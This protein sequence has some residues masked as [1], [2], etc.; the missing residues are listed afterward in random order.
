[1]AR[2]DFLNGQ[3][4]GISDSRKV[5]Q[6]TATSGFVVDF[7]TGQQIEMPGARTPAVFD[8]DRVLYF[9]W[10]GL[11]ELNLA[12]ELVATWEGGTDPFGRTSSGHVVFGSNMGTAVL[13]Q[14]GIRYGADSE[15]QPELGYHGDISDEG[16]LIGTYKNQDGS[17]HPA[18]W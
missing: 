12:G 9:S 4:V 6:L 17:T 3:A 1:G 14:W 7:A 13:A 16:A 5:V 2:K 8:V 15:K 10:G 18:R 11:V